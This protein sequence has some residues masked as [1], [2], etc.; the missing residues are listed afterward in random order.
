MTLT[1]GKAPVTSSYTGSMCVLPVGSVSYSSNALIPA[2]HLVKII[3][4]TITEATTVII[5]A[6]PRKLIV[7]T[8]CVS[9]ICTPNVSAGYTS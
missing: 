2:L 8:V 5:K 4:I 7:Y 3:V 1:E 9:E 6:V